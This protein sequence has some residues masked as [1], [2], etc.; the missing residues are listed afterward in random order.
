MFGLSFI[1]YSYF[2]AR[3]MPRDRI[4]LKKNKN[5]HIQKPMLCWQKCI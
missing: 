2:Y 1:P 5:S 4:L 3:V